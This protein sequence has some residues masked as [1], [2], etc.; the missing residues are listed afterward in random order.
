MKIAVLGASGRS[1][2][3]VAQ[4][5]L[6]RGD[7]VRAVVRD[8]D[9]LVR[10]WSGG[11]LPSTARADATDVVAL[12]AAFE[13][14]DAVAFCLGSDRGAAHTIHREGISACLAAMDS[15]GT[16]RIVALSASGMVTDGDDPLSRYL[17]KPIVGRILAANFADLLAMEDQLARSSMDWTVVRPPRL[18]NRAGTGS[19]RQRRD[20]NVRWRFTISRAD[21]ALAIVN[22]LHDESSIGAFVSVAG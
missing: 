11:N 3:L 8:P 20:G 18:T 5:A 14:Q 6:L 15:A 13:G 4:Q 2:R 12:A 9:R 17:A 1:G 10:V 19:Y 22:A 16:K 21:L 7:E